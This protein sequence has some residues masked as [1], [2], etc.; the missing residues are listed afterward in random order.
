MGKQKYATSFILSILA[1]HKLVTETLEPQSMRCFHLYKH[2]CSKGGE[3]FLGEVRLCWFSLFLS[4]I[5][6]E[7]IF[8]PRYSIGLLGWACVHSCMCAD[9]VLSSCF[10][11]KEWVLMERCI[12]L[13]SGIASSWNIQIILYSIW[14]KET[15]K[16][17]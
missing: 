6:K 10:K 3:G 12:S 7:V 15:K 14:G 13:V 9:W 11:R 2:P 8:S 1:S 5:F 16:L 17:T 4:K